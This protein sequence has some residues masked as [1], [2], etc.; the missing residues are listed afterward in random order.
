MTLIFSTS[1]CNHRVVAVAGVVDVVVVVVIVATFFLFVSIHELS[2]YEVMM[3]HH[4]GGP[5]HTRATQ[6][7]FAEASF[8]FWRV[9][10]SS[11][12]LFYFTSSFYYFHFS[13][14]AANQ[15]PNSHTDNDTS[16]F[17]LYTVHFGVDYE[18]WDERYE[19]KGTHLLIAHLFLLAIQLCICYLFFGSLPGDSLTSG[20]YRLIDNCVSSARNEIHHRCRRFHRCHC[21][22]TKEHLV[23]VTPLT[24]KCTHTHI[25]CGPF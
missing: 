2:V 8:C 7:I 3:Y 19:D 9:I 25:L 16:I 4:V 18:E 11:L 12:L 10:F 20:H 6:S 13:C 22:R 5:I 17:D 23:T 24:H 21:R 1:S 15:I 14:S